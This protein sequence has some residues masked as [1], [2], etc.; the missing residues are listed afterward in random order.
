MQKRW[1]DPKA[2]LQVCKKDFITWRKNCVEQR[3]VVKLLKT[4][5]FVGKVHQLMKNDTDYIMRSATAAEKSIVNRRKG[6]RLYVLSSKSKGMGNSNR[7][8]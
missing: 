8:N 5:L 3:E 2:P 1:Q 7:N 6:R 4:E